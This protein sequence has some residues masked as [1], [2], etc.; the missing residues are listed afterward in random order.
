MFLTKGTPLL[1]LLLAD[2]VL[3][4]RIFLNPPT[5]SLRTPSSL[6]P[7]Q[8]RA[9]VSRHLGLEAFDTLQ[10]VQGAEQLVSGE[11]VGKDTGNALLLTLSEDVARGELHSSYE[12]DLYLC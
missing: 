1:F 3:G 12:P 5:S 7:T 6:T 10:D 11:F 8:A 4:I 9:V 2:V